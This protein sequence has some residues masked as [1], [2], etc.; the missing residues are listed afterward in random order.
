[1]Y[2]LIFRPSL[3]WRLKTPTDSCLHCTHTETRMNLQGELLLYQTISKKILVLIIKLM[4][5]KTF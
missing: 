3:E 2:A 1:M 5:V 4:I